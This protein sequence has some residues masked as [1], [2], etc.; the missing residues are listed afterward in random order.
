MH[1]NSVPPPF[2]REVAACSFGFSNRLK[3]SP[4]KLRLCQQAVRT[5]LMTALA[6][7][8]PLVLFGQRGNASKQS[9]AS[10]NLAVTSPAAGSILSGSSATFTWTASSSVSQYQLWLG[11]TGVGS[12]NLT[13]YTFGSTKAATESKTVSGLP[14]TGAILYVRLLWQ[15]NGAWSSSD[16]TYIEANTAAVGVSAVSCSSA[17]LNGAGSDP[18]SVTLSAAANSAEKVSLASNNSAVKVPSSVTVAAGASSAAFTATATAVGTAQTATLTATAGGTSQTYA[19]QLNAAAPALSLSAAS[20][21]FGT[22]PLNQVATKAVTLTSSGT[23]PLTI[24]AVMTAG[25][26]F[27][28]QGLGATPMTLAPGQSAT[29]VITFN[30]NSASAFSGTATIVDNTPTDTT[31]SLTGTGQN[32]SPASAAVSA[33]S[34]SS[35]A[36]TGAGTDACTVMLSSAATNTTIVSLM[37]SNSAVTVPPSVTVTG[38]ASLVGFTATASAV[39]TTQ[40]ATLTATAGGASTTYALQLNPAIPAMSLSTANV[41]FGNVLVNTP[42]SQTVTVTS[43]GMAQLIL[44][45]ATVTGTAFS[46]SGI[47]APITLNPGQT[48]VLTIGFD[49]TSTGAASGTVT[50]GSNA[51]SSPTITLSGTGQPGA[52]LSAVSC[53]SAALTGAATDACAVTLT[54]TAATAMTVSLTSSSSAVTVPASVTVAAGAASA[55]FTATATAVTTAQTATLTATSAGVSVTYPLQLNA[56]VPGLSLS[57]TNVA[58]GNV[59]VNTPTSQTVTVTSSG[60]AQ[61]ILSGATATGA[62]FS[63]SGINAPITLNPGQTAVLTVGFDPTS[64]GAAS[65]SVTISSNAPSSPTITLSGTGQPGATLSA[66]SCT[67]AS[68]TGAA[69]DACTVTLTSAATSPVTVNLTSSNSSVTAPAS[70]A[71]GAGASS[72]PFT[73]TATAVTTAQTATLT[74]TAA[75]VSVTYPLQLNAATVA[76]NASTTSVAFGNVIENTTAT[77]PVT[78]S[79]SGTVALI[80]SSVSVSG[81]G[82]GISGITFP[83]TLNPSQTT[84]L[85]L[86]FTPTTLS[87]STGTLTLSSNALS[88]GTTSI[89]LS[90]TGIAQAY[91]VE[92]AWNAPT[93]STDPVAGYNVYRTTGN[94]TFAV[95][96]SSPI[97]QPSWTDTTVQ[98]GASYSYQITSVDPSGI[99]STPST[100]S[101]VSIP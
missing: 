22:E 47:G 80:L 55:A 98:N 27:S 78:L 15:V 48:A 31:I 9:P 17:S 70:I 69:T 36:L 101:A 38:G 3:L 5:G 72:A 88:G 92:L 41:A 12:E 83:L 75:G 91:Q 33:V 97:S 66:V 84:T 16:S 34:C 30:P 21:A 77:Q 20:V 11:T 37:S 35:A 95:M 2:A 64:T 90:G 81:T 23:A 18:C 52:T 63:V 51:S 60:T 67:S 29:L 73:A 19:L 74:A 4:K 7:C 85:N 28:W 54:G 99:E 44:N 79:A 93:A 32:T 39:T 49:P 57:T 96:N 14:T 24:Y 53:G 71:I 62:A 43:S 58:F 87:S 61:L 42:T 50:I 13:A 25:S 59:L 82:F 26:G 76:L 45:G 89:S 40:T 65:G 56:V 100:P 1:V 10:V 86:S 46:V 8:L 94:G 6:C 68:L